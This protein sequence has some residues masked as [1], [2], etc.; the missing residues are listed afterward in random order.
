[1]SN[2]IYLG[3]LLDKSSTSSKE[4]ERLVGSVEVIGQL[5]KPLWNQPS[6]SLETISSKYTGRRSVNY[7]IWLSCFEYDLVKINQRNLAGMRSVMSNFLNREKSWE[8]SRI[9]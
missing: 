4:I 7:F 9:S 1:M 5:Q 6:V 8:L 2:I 3:S